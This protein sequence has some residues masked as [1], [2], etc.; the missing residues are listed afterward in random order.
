[1][2]LRT[3]NYRHA[4]SI[5]NANFRLKKE[6]ERILGQLQFETAVPARRMETYSLHRQIQRAFLRRNWQGEVLV[7]PR[8][9][10]RHRFDMYKER[11][12]VEIELSHRERLYRDYLRFVMAEAEDRIDLGVIILLDKTS[13]PVHAAS[14][15]GGV[16]RLEDVE[17]DLKMLHAAI[18]V[19]IW[20]LALS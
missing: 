16:P 1:M 7:S 9:A 19:P 2:N 15:W 12:A 14:K 6:I 8:T 20:A 3:Y 10:H 4:E 18:T 5:L 11:V 13:V 17:D